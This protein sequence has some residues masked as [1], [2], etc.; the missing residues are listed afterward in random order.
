MRKNPF[1]VVLA[2]LSPLAATLVLL[3]LL[4]TS[5]SAAKETSQAPSTTSEDTV[6]S[7]APADMGNASSSPASS[8]AEALTIY[9]YDSFCS[10]W[11]PGPGIVAMFQEQTGISVDLIS[12]GDGGQVLQRTIV[13]KNSPK[14][15]IVI[16]IDNNLLQSALRTGLFLPYQSPQLESV[17][18]DLI[19]DPSYQFLPFDYGYFSII[20]DSRVISE[21]PTSLDDLLDPAFD[22]SLILMD[23]RTSTPGLGFLLWT[24]AVYGDD[25]L[26]YWDRLKNS[27]LTISDG[28]DTGYGLFTQGEAPMVLSYTT[29]PAYHV[30]YEEIDHFRSAL[31]TEGHLSQIEG[32]GILR[33]SDQIDAAK[34]F[35]DFMLG[36]QAQETI[37][38]TNWMYPVN[39]SVGL[40]ASYDFAPEPAKSLQL[41]GDYLSEHL[42]QILHAW[43]ETMSH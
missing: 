23:P 34:L 43:T 13:E 7:T 37:P 28:W 40:P 32:L 2:V 10:D 29:S 1:R 12:A 19:F 14:A 30:E 39:S 17:D 31:F 25:Y 36:T 27:I 33:S 35:V 15:D 38:L 3:T 20:Y 4:T 42:D 41:S 5:C 21:P 16:G 18:K 6:V 24:I 11:G 8:E 9:A 26:S 22:R